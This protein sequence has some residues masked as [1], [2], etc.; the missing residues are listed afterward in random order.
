MGQKL[1]EKGNDASATD[2]SVEE[3][4]L[5]KLRKANYPTFLLDNYPVEHPKRVFQMSGSPVNEEFFY[6]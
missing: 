5:K 1:T 3:E 6:V 2:L 4:R